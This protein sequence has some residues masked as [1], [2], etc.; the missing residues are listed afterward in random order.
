MLFDSD[1]L[2]VSTTEACL[3]KSDLKTLKK[4]EW[5]GDNVLAFH[6]EWLQALAG[7]S[8]ADVNVKMFPPAVVEVLCTLDSA[9][10][11]DAASVVPRPEERFLLLPVSD[12]Y[13]PS[14]PGHTAAGSHWSLLLV[15]AAS[16]VA[17]HL[18]SLGDCNRSA[19]K[20]VHSSILMLVRPRHAHHAPPP[21]P[22]KVDCLQH[23]ENGSD[24]GIF[25]LLLS[26][27]I[28]LWLTKPQAS[29]YDLAE[30]VQAVCADTTPSKVGQFRRLYKDWLKSW[31]KASHHEE[32][33][34]PTQKVKADFLHL[35]SEI[36]VE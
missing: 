6:A 23:Q 31:G 8:P 18:D 20:A 1:P 12:R 32:H 2:V 4:E 19:A 15:D 26:S 10:A 30:V 16:G 9:A 22:F 28:H 35:F 25:V 5:L 13:S 27:L 11:P 7:G 14:S 17:F 3:H 34:D 33:V 21:V 24:C 36:G 29:T